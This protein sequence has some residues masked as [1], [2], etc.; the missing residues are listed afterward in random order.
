M[1]NRLSHAAL[2]AA[3]LGL[4]AGV[5]SAADKDA[6]LA[7]VD[8]EIEMQI[9][10]SDLRSPW[11]IA[12]LPDGSWLLAEQ[13]GSL[14]H[15]GNDGVP[16]SV[17]GVPQS[18]HH[19]QGGLMEIA[20]HPDFADNRWL[21]I[22][23]THAVGEGDDLRYMT[24]LDRGKFE[25]GRLRELETLFQAPEE[26]YRSATQHFGCR[27]AFDEKNRLYFSI[28]DRGARHDAQDLGRANGK[29][30]RLQ[31]DGDIPEGN[32]FAD[33]PGAIPG[34][35]TYGHRNPQGLAF[36]PET[37]DLW[38]A[39]H[40]PRGGDELNLIEKGENYGWPI[41]TYGTEYSREV[42]TFER[43]REGLVHP[44]WHWTPSIAPC[45]I[46]FY[47]GDEFPLWNGNLLVT[48]LKFQQLQRVQI[49]DRRVVNIETILEGEGR[50]RDVASAPDGSIYVLLN[51]PGRV[52]RLVRTGTV[53]TED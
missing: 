46:A 6:S 37:G 12:F 2:L 15:F 53:F 42:I 7:T 20:L 27:I 18:W 33:R 31:D 35:H 48:S 43:D 17:A 22:A 16:H 30:Y 3:S 36:H 38:A 23:Y 29:I 25:E 4:F 1:R 44:V 40:G 19:G 28:G 14:L 52:V 26:Q 47:Q 45:G 8:Y 11:S 10:A 5:S 24:K 41:V 9:V 32:P 21:Y 13:E 34:I 39:E 49:H 51:A 50:V